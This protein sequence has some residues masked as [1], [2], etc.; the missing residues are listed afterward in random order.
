MHIG[1]VLG[2]VF[3]SL[4]AF[5][6]WEYRL[7]H[8]LDAWAGLTGLRVLTL[9]GVLREGH[10][11]DLSAPPGFRLQRIE[12]GKY[13]VRAAE[14]NEP[15]ARLDTSFPWI[16]ALF[17]IVGRE[18]T[19]DVRFG[20]GILVTFSA[21]VATLL[22]RAVMDGFTLAAWTAAL[23]WTSFVAL[24]FLHLRRRVRSTFTKF[25]AYLTSADSV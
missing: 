11:G 1:S 8:D 7:I 24:G 4:F 19:L 12:P 20:L 9:R 2:L 23:A 16:V 15:G 13:L 21:A 3:V 17:R 6:F 10:S 5:T 22:S 25:A 14:W 18:W